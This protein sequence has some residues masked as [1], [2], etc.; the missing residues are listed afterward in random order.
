MCA[1]SAGDVA[2]S[3]PENLLVTLD[4]IFESESVADLMTKGKISELACL[5]LYL[6]YEK[7]VRRGR[8]V[9]R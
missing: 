5:T 2:I 7:K 6:M 4:R 8:D 1:S 9:C 3:I